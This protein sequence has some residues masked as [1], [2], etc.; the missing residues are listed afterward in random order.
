[1]D[2]V[3]KIKK[4]KASKLNVTGDMVVQ[5]KLTGVNVRGDRVV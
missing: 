3:S 5:V 4:Y 2:K 1:M